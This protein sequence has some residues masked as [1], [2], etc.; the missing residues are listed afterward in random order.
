MTVDVGRADT[1]WEFE[2]VTASH[3]AGDP[4]GTEGAR[5]SEAVKLL[6]VAGRVYRSAPVTVKFRVGADVRF[7]NS[8]SVRTEVPNHFRV[9][10]PVRHRG[11]VLGCHGGGG[12]RESEVR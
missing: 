7:E 6:R 8:V 9:R 5:W 3:T 1:V 10:N 2:G 11:V 12:A 4:R